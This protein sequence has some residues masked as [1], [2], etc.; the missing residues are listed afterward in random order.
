MIGVKSKFC[1]V[2]IFDSEYNL[3]TTFLTRREPISM[4]KFGN[5]VVVG[6]REH[7]FL[8]ITYNANLEG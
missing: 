1:S 7:A 2:R 5:I 3:V 8:S 4:T 6:M